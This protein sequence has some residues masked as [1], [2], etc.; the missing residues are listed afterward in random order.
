MQLT[1][2]KH[3]ILKPDNIIEKNDVRINAKTSFRKQKERLNYRVSK[4]K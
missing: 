2:Y 4:K 3:A 1:R